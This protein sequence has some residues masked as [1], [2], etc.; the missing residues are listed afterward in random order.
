MLNPVRTD[1]QD[2]IGAC[3]IISDVTEQRRAEEAL[4]KSEANLR[5]ILDNADTAY[6]LLNN[7]FDILSF[8]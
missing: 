3:F 6:V 4:G 5:T 7:K 8:N 1:R 2:V